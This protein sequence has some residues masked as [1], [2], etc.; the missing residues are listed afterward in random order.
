MEEVRVSSAC[1]TT[2]E[3]I[4]DGGSQDFPTGNRVLHLEAA[5]LHQTTSYVG[6][7]P[8]KARHAAAS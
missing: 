2:A 3:S 8:K 6:F 4:E 1:A 7:R 5:R